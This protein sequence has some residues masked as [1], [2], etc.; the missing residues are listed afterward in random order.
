MTDLID[1]LK[2]SQTLAISSSSVFY[3]VVC[4]QLLGA[5][6]PHSEVSVELNVT[7]GEKQTWRRT[8]VMCSVLQ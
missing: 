5:L 1:F 4:K 7:S 8:D 2:I 3:M 6:P